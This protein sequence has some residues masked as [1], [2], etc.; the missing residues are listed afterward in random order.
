VIKRNYDNE[1]KQ[2]FINWFS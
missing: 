1:L 2:D